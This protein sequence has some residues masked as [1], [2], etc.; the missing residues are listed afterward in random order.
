MKP[1]VTRKNISGLRENF[2]GPSTAKA[3]RAA[4][5]TA[6]EGSGKCAR[7]SGEPSEI[8]DRRGKT[9]QRG[10][11]DRLFLW[12]KIDPHDSVVTASQKLNGGKQR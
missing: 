2:G 12:V 8:S 3:N 6:K 5:G 4:K 1:E 9:E 7:K 11:G 10:A